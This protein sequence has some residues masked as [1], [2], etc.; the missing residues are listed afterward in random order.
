VGGPGSVTFRIPQSR[1]VT[2]HG[3]WKDGRWAVVMKRSLTVPSDD[4]GVSLAPNATSSV[5][6]AVWD[7]S[8]Q[9]R[10][11]KKLVSIWQNLKLEP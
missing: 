1:L 2:A 9:D 7:G 10:D 8:E 11:G 5:A 6:F 4:D 3:D